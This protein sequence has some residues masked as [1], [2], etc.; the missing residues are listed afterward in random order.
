MPA[1]QS[2]P[3]LQHYVPRFLL[4]RFANER[5]QL[6]TLDLETE[7]IYVQSL[8]SAAAKRDYNTIYD[9]GGHRGQ[10]VEHSLAQMEGHFATVLRMLVDGQ[11]TAPVQVPAS[12]RQLI[13][14]FILIQWARTPAGRQALSSA[15]DAELKQ[16]IRE[17][18]PQ[19]LREMFDAERDMPLTDKEAA[20]YWRILSDETYY[21]FTDYTN[22][23]VRAGLGNSHG[24][25]LER[26]QALTDRTIILL[27][28]HKKTLL[29][30]DQPVLTMPQGDFER[31]EDIGRIDP[32]EAEFILIPV[33]RKK[34][35]IIG[36][37]CGIRYIHSRPGTTLLAR[38]I[39]EI[40]IVAADRHV[41]SH[42][43]DDLFGES[44]NRVRLREQLVLSLEQIRPFA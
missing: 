31:M 1:R 20:E 39:N 44:E 40:G 4:R 32:L 26:Q 15:T 23:L 9:D 17:A 37:S 34:A 27:E 42:P 5:N 30:G 10:I 2:E 14:S 3:R 11:L 6:R 29:I 43:D 16:Q 41:F 12:I 35:L 25:W 7:R 18:G 13:A 19:R 22:N 36:P 28:W 38:L 21:R 33:S 8:N 24:N